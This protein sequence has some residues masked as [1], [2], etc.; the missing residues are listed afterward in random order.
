MRTL[1][2]SSLIV[3]LALP[4]V[5]Q[6]ERAKKVLSPIYLF[7]ISFTSPIRVGIFVWKIRHFY[8]MFASISG[9]SLITWSSR[10]VT[11]MHAGKPFHQLSSQLS[12]VLMVISIK[13]FR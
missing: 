3:I 4:L 12:T 1:T 8:K 6:S 2:G 10:F 11:L 9:I 5:E 13:C 7:G